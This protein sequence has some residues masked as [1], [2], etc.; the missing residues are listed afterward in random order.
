[1]NINKKNKIKIAIVLK[2][3]IYFLINKKSL[4][5]QYKIYIIF[6]INQNYIHKLEFLDYF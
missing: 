6:L 2:V 5:N 3:F 4:K 1:M